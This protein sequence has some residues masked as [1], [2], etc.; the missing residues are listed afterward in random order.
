MDSSIVY[1][2]GVGPSRGEL[3]MTELGIR[4]Y[5]DLLHHFPFRYIDRS[6]FHKIRD[7]RDENTLVQLQA[8]LVDKKVIAQ[9]RGSRLEAYVTDET[10]RLKLTWFQGAK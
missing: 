2:K 5:R 4:A 1:L 9:K 6:Q 3:L 7:I 10:G 8:T